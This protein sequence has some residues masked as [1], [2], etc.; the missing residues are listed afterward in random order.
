MR[1]RTI[2][3]YFSINAGASALG[4][5]VLG[6]LSDAFGPR[7]A[8]MLGGLVALDASDE[9]GAETVDGE[10]TCDVERLRG[11]NV[12][13]DLR[14]GDLC[15]VHKRRRDCRARGYGRAVARSPVPVCSLLRGHKSLASAARPR[16]A[17]QACRSRR[18]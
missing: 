18:R 10:S 8:L 15:E 11:G 6:A 2:A 17:F 7:F 16:E 13:F 1:G 4:S 9:R 14:I 12:R 5:F 3:L